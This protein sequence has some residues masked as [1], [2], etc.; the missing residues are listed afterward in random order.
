M[1]MSFWKPQVSDTP[2]CKALSPIFFPFVQN[3]EKKSFLS[4]NLVKHIMQICGFYVRWW[5]AAISPLAP[6]VISLDLPAPTGWDLLGLGCETSGASQVLPWLSWWPHHVL[7]ATSCPS[8][9]RHGRAQV[10]MTRGSRASPCP[11]LS[12]H[13]SEGKTLP[14]EKFWGFQGGGKGEHLPCP[15]QTVLLEAIQTAERAFPSHPTSWATQEKWMER[16]TLNW[17]NTFLSPF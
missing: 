17:F 11:A 4:F 8:T 6:A 10:P 15:E 12:G 13:C 3:G 2:F 9:T 14:K 1:T 5:P 16:K 7:T